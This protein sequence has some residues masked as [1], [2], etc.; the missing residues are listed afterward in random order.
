MKTAELPVTGPVQA[1]IEDADLAADAAEQRH[2]RGEAETEAEPVDAP[3]KDQEAPE[4]ADKPARDHDT[5]RLATKLMLASAVTS[6]FA[7]LYLEFGNGLFLGAASTA[8]A[9]VVYW[10]AE[11]NRNRA[12]RA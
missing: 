12:G 7:C 5:R 3:A 1:S 2:E 10:V 11:R 9:L 4:A 6:F 8:L